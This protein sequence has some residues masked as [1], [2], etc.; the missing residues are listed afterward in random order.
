MHWQQRDTFSL[1][2]MVTSGGW[3]I[4]KGTFV[5]LVDLDTLSMLKFLKLSGDYLNP[6]RHRTAPRWGNG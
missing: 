6:L 4:A 2:S 5:S 3:L 1:Q